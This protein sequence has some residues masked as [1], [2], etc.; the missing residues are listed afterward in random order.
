[1]IEMTKNHTGKMEGINSISTSVVLNP[2]CQAQQAVK[3]SI[4]SHCF[5]EAMMKM[6]SAL[7]DKLARNT[8]ILTESVLPEDELPDTTGMKIFRFESFGDLNNEIQLINYLNIA[9]K[10]PE[11]RFTLWTKRYAIVEKYFA[12]HDVPENFT[13]IISSLMVNIKMPLTFLKKT[14]KFKLGQLKSFTVYDYDYIKEHWEEMNINCGSRFCLG[15]RL[16]YDLNDVEEISEVLKADQTRVDRFLKCHDP[17]L[18]AEQ[19]DLLS[20]LDDLL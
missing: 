10:N 18:I 9:K 12:E 1:M 3:G 15:C 20:E 13:L 19:M 8:K 11:T 16:C 17:K 5:A 6:Y 14:G 2:F 4:C 7:E